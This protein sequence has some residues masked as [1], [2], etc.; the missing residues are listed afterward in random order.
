MRG[1]VYDSGPLINRNINNYLSGKFRDPSFLRRLIAA[2]LET[3]GKGGAIIGAASFGPEGASFG[4]PGRISRPSVWHNGKYD[5]HTLNRYYPA[6]L[7]EETAFDTW[8]LSWLLDENRTS[9][10]LKALAKDLLGRELQQYDEV[11]DDPEKLAAYAVE[12]ACATYDLFGL[13]WDAAADQGLLDDFLAIEINIFPLLV[14]MESRGVRVDVELLERRMAEIGPRVEQARQRLRDS[15]DVDWRCVRCLGAKT[16]T[17]K[18]G[19]SRGQTLPC[20]DCE[21]SGV[22]DTWFTS[23]QRLGGVLFKQLRYRPVSYTRTKQPSTT[24]DDLKTLLAQRHHPFVAELVE[25]REL[26]KLYGTYYQPYLEEHVRDGRI[27]PDI[28]AWKPRT[29]RFSCAKPNLQ[30]VPQAVRDLF[31]PDEGQVFIVGDYS[32]I[33]MYLAGVLSGERK[34]LDAYEQ[35][36]DLHT[37]TGEITGLDRLGSKT[38]NFGILYGLTE[39]SLSNRL[40]VTADEGKQIY[41]KVIG[42]YATLHQY[43]EGCKRQARDVGY[44]KTLLGRRRRILG[45]DSPDR[46]V[47]FHAENQAVN[48]PVQGSAA[49]L[50][51]AAMIKLKRR[52]P[53]AE[54]LLQVHDEIVAQAP[55]EQ[56]QEIAKEFK[57]VM[58]SALPGLKPRAEVR[59]TE[60]WVK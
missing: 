15:L 21:G 49:D 41:H 46:A 30:N 23:P 47:R 52:L 16:W 11:K 4:E 54:Q 1:R 59:V 34:I 38:V 26:E 57:A 40:G 6:G 24:A 32:Q 43:L 20:P 12:D 17:Y 48:S 19:P 33:E 53:E 56:A 22:D 10:G 25:F 2:D 55:V 60:R 36:H 5:F 45:I 8:A 27:H 44:V 13:L 28:I 51:K 50:I 58:E 14:E 7:P 9:H 39:R 18:G 3:E 42:G 31:L 37:R 35:G 29:G